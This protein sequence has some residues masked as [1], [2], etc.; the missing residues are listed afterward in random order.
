LTLTNIGGG[1]VRT[2][3]PGSLAA[4]ALMTTTHVSDAHAALLPRV[5][6]RVVDYVGL[7]AADRSEAEHRTRAILATAGVDAVWH[8]TT[9]VSPADSGVTVL[10]LAPSMAARQL[11]MESLGRR[12]LGLAAPEPARRVWVHAN[13]VAEE[14]AALHTSTGQLLAHV[15]SHETLHVLAR[16]LHTDHG[17][18]SRSP[19]LTGDLLDETLTAAER[20]QVATA[21]Q[22]REKPMQLA[23]RQR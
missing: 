9:V 22:T 3:L 13:A 15:I 7:P 10:L 4:L 11:A 5:D 20:L 12:L 21:L 1:N 2:S 17:L 23:A 14:A 6:L 16:L 18:M 19:R 8:D